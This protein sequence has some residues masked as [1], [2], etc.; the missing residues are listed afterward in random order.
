MP[1][2][3]FGWTDRWMDGRTGRQMMSNAIVADQLLAAEVTNNGKTPVNNSCYNM[4]GGGEGSIQQALLIKAC[5]CFSSLIYG[6][7]I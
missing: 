3:H 5:S 2:L 1:E 7:I 4:V 6:H